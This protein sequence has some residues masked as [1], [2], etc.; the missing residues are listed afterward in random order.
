MKKVIFLSLVVLSFSSC[1]TVLG[2]QKTDHQRNKAQC[3]EPRRQLRVGMIVA[4]LL[5]FPPGLI[6]DFATKKIYKPFPNSQKI[7]EC[8]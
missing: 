7:K 5:F 1:A 3:G 6:I 2:G 8:K 4:D